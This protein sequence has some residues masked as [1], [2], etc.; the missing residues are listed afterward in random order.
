ML[1]LLAAAVAAVFAAICIV[2][3]VVL[4]AVVLALALGV[5]YVFR[6]ARAMLGSDVRRGATLRSNGRRGASPYSGER[7]S[8]LSRPN[9]SVRR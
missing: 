2:K 8:P 3:L 9:V 7:V 1:L 6:F 4:A 5:A